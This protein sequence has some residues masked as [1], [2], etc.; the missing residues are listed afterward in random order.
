MTEEVELYDSVVDRLLRDVNYS[1][2]GYVPS[3]EAF[4]FFNFIQLVNGGRTENANPL[5]HYKM[6]DN[7][8]HSDSEKHAIMSHRGIAKSMIFGVYLPLYMAVTGRMPGF[9]EVNYVI[10]VADS[11]ENNVRTTMN[12]A[13]DL[14][15]SSDFLQDKFETAKFTDT[16]MTLVRKEE[17]GKPLP[18]VQRRFYMAGYGAS[19]GVRGTRKGTDRPQ[20]ALIDDLIKSN[21]D[22]RSEAILR[23]IRETVYSDVMNALHPSQRKIIWTGTPFN[24]NDPLYMAIDSGVWT[25]SVYPVATDISTDMD[26]S[27]FEGSWPDR[28]TYKSVMKNYTDS[29]AD[30]SIEEFM[31]EMM[32]RIT[33]DENRLIPDSYLIW[34][35]RDDV[36]KNKEAYN[37]YVTTDLA[38]SKSSTA[39]MA[40]I[41]I[42]AINH[43]GDHML[44]DGQA[45]RGD[46][47]EHISDL[48]D[49]CA[50]YNPLS[51]GIEISGQQATFASMLRD[52]MVQE[53]RYFNI[54]E[55]KHGTPGI[56]TPHG[57]NKYTNFLGILHL[58]S[59]NKI[60]FPNEMKAEFLIQEALN[61]LRG[62]SKTNTGKR[63][64]SAKHDD[65]IDCMAQLQHMDI[66]APSETQKFAPNEDTGIY[67]LMPDDEDLGGSSYVF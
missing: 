31:Q 23:S 57:K 16:R 47:S 28:F 44:V 13:R 50:K 42:W 48:F 4:A 19:T 2:P 55:Q 17:I 21:S 54:Y 58:F 30:G 63:I 10:Y 52:K 38:T 53:N 66:H 25:P 59:N 41:L 67:E 46:P 32:L 6:I 65:V 20:M 26:E 64:G 7:L 35:N 62:V 27:D 1:F 14:Y 40:V 18:I 36:L 29:I 15:E 43:K 49:L 5:V 11:M 12:T 3:K 45:K 37:F 34:Y 33:S 22:A 8:F 60:W 24:Q 61:E 39:D 51:V 56:R 9:G